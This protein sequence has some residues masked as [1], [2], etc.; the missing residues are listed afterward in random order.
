MA[1]M[2]RAEPNPH[3]KL[4]DLPF[5]PAAARNAAPILAQLRAWLPAQAF[6]LEVASGTGQ[7]AQ[8]FAA[9]QLGWQWQP[10]EV[11]AEWLSVVAVRCA[12]Q[13]NVRP[14]VQLDV[15]VQPWLVEAASVDAVYVANLL[16]ISPW[17]VT[18]ALMQGAARCLKPGGVLVVYGPFIVPGESLAPSN[19]A[20]DADLRLRD[21]RWGLR[22]LP[23]VQAAAEQAE[24]RLVERCAMP[25][26]NL[27][28][29]FVAMP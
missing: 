18:P 2:S 26:N 5:S 27:I 3:P 13:P 8:H 16:H 12:G 6:V 1:A 11:Q 17:E 4:A 7:H 24:L 21:A 14:P 25:A 28:L 19:A 20:F 15:Q 9:A 29:R 23:D 10:S 22:L